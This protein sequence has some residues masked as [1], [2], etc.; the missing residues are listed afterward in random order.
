MTL[1]TCIEQFRKIF[2]IGD[3]AERHV[4]KGNAVWF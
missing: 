1:E 2:I 3:C 4:E